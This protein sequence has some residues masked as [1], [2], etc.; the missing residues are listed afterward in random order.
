MKH[1][2]PIYTVGCGAWIG[3]TMTVPGVSGG[4]MAMILG[5]Y[6]T[7]I[8]SVNGVFKKEKRKESLIYLACFMAGAV[9]GLVLF[10]KLIT[11]ALEHFPLPTSYFFIGAVAGAIPMI[12]RSANIKKF[13]A[14]VIYLPL[15]GAIVALSIA[16]IP[17]GLLELRNDTVFDLLFSILIQLVGGVFI[18]IAI[19]LPGVSFSQVLLVLGLHEPIMSALGNLDI[20]A[21]LGF[22]P[23]AVGTAAGVFFVTHFIEIALTKYPT[24]S[25]LIIFGFILGSLPDLV[26]REFPL[27]WNLPICFLTA[28]A[29]FLA[30][31]FISQREKA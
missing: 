30:I 8:G 13:K 12:F 6:D 14:S 10:A 19:V 22:I 17:E 28:A 23:L 25:Y 29:G 11:L 9:V 4:S 1:H 7:L 5:I 26:P 18:A 20:V 2:N 21:L 15:I 24:A 31:V 3:G 16:L 27:G